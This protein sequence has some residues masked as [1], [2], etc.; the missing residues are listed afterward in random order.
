MQAL[1]DMLKHAA[2][3]VVEA[4]GCCGLCGA[5]QFGEELADV[6]MCCLIAAAWHK[7]DV[8]K[9]LRDCAEKN[10]ARA[11]GKGDKK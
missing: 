3:E 2:T 8:E 4:A 1:F 7:V 9:A 10:R 6:V 11:E 5:E